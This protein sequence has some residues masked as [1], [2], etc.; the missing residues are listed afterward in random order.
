MGIMK[1][2]FLD[3]LLYGD[4]FE[5]AMAAFL[6]LM[7]VICLAFILWGCILMIDTVGTKSRT[8]NAQLVERHYS[9]AWTQTT[10][11][12]AGKV[13][14]PQIIYHPESWSVDVVTEED[15]ILNC[16]CSKHLHDSFG[17]GEAVVATV[18]SGRLSKKTYCQGV[19][20]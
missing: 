6:L 15:Q 19:E 8:V 20:R 4:F 13:M 5:R 1:D 11:I 10:M 18:Y 14:V 17:K 2:F 9:P 16:D 3:D 7:L 12:M